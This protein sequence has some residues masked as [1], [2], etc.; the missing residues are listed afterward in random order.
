MLQTVPQ[1]VHMFG[2][3]IRCCVC[4][5]LLPDMCTC[6]HSSQVSMCIVHSHCAQ[7]PLWLCC[8]R[9]G[10]WLV[11]LAT[12]RA[13]TARSLAASRSTVSASK[14]AS[15]AGTTANALTART[16]RCVQFTPSIKHIM[17]VQHPLQSCAYT[18]TLGSAATDKRPSLR[19]DVLLC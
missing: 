3:T 13:A 4:T 14:Q 15:T 9:R 17:A 19:G 5:V 8:R 12:T 10:L 2:D 1:H 7:T 11:L 18:L 6:K 16:L